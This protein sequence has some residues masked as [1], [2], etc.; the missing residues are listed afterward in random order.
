MLN[1]QFGCTVCSCNA[2]L[3]RR[4]CAGKS[5]WSYSEV[6][7]GGVSNHRGRCKFCTPFGCRVS[8]WKRNLPFTAYNGKDTA[9]RCECSCWARAA[10]KQ[11]CVSNERRGHT[12]I[13]QVI[14][15]VL[16]GI[17]SSWIWRRICR[18][19]VAGISKQ[20]AAFFFRVFV[21]LSPCTAPDS[22]HGGN[23]LFQRS[24]NVYQTT[25]R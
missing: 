23:K 15:A 25:W 5:N 8:L 9:E 3:S 11:Q 1:Y 21:V 20:L 7:V 6:K 16:M 13:L 4:F 2:R 10:G 24:L 14:T 17:R 12:A 22:A 18:P 19:I